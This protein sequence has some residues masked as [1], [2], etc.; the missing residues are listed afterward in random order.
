MAD[1]TPTAVALRARAYGYLRPML[2]DAYCCAGAGADGY[3]DA[4]FEVVGVD[5]DP[6]PNYPYEF[7][8]AD[9]LTMLADPDFMARFA[10]AHASPPC[11]AYSDLQKQNKRDYPDLIGPTR[12]LLRASGLPHI[13]ENVEGA[14]LLDPTVLCGTMFPALRVNRHRLF[15]SSVPLRAPRACLS[16]HP[17]VFT[18]DKRKAHYGKLDQ[19]TSYVQVTGGGNCTIA[20]ALDAMGIDRPMTKHEVNEAI[21]P[22]YTHWL[23]LQLR[24]A[25]AAPAFMREAA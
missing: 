12:D 2:L 4:G 15:E 1:S 22:A 13:I 7:I 11:Q 23:G 25:L 20:N 3:H 17:L 19:D 18:H 9:A 8:Q 24:M 5:K 21:P 6:Q 10:A 16:P 14:P